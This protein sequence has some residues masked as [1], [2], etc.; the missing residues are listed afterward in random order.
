M[1]L[2]TLTLPTPRAVHDRADD[3]DALAATVALGSPEARAA[4][5]AALHRE[6]RRRG[7]APASIHALYQAIGRGDVPPTFTVPAMNLRVLTY[8]TARAA[9]RA[10]RTLDA[11]A[12]LFELA[13][14]EMGYTDQRPREYAAL[15]VAAALREGHEG[16]VFIQGDH[17]QASPSRWPKDPQGE[18]GALRDLIDEALA[19]GY[20]NMDIDASTLVDLSKPTLREQQRVN[21]EV[22]TRLTRYVREKEP[23]VPV[24]IGVEIGEVGHKNSNPE[25]LRAFMDEYMSLLPPGMEG[26]AKISV[27]TGTS[28]GGTVTASGEIAEAKVDFATLGELTRIARAEY[29]MGG[30]VQHGASTLPDRAFHLFPEAGCV[31]IHLATGFQNLVLDHPALPEGLR[32]QVAEYVT[33]NHAAQRKPGETEAQFQYKNRKYAL[34]PLKAAFW[35]LPEPVRDRLGRDLEAKFAFLFGELRIGR[36]LEWARRHA[37]TPKALPTAGAATEADLGNLLEGE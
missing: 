2:A 20:L 13:R 8:D 28:H 19:A 23:G 32:R 37:L 9:F 35:D 1:S 10:A 21:A 26:P 11:G 12:L 18:E 31:E 7:C 17:F 27:Q 14:S 25:E 36:T 6:A 16:P 29:G 33:A 22:S 3:F 24:S 4:A 34:G 5:T 15:I 30:A